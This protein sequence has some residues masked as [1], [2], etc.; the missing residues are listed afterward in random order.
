MAFAYCFGCAGRGLS[1]PCQTVCTI[2]LWCQNGSVIT[3]ITNYVLGIVML[4]AKM[5]AFYEHKVYETSVIV[6]IYI[7]RSLNLRNTT[8]LAKDHTLWREPRWPWELGS[9][10][11]S[12]RSACTLFSLGDRRVDGMAPLCLPCLCFLKA[13]WWLFVDS[14]QIIKERLQIGCWPTW[15]AEPG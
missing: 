12:G 3:V 8:R 7:T 1:E 15:Q 6:S 5:I 2:T 9:L 11:T 10:V 14:F 13:R 4:F